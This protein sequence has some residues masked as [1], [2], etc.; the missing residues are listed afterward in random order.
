MLETQEGKGKENM[1]YFE[2]RERLTKKGKPSGY[3]DFTCR[4]DNDIWR[5]GYCRE[6]NCKHKTKVEACDHYRQ[7]QLD[8]ELFLANVTWEN[9]WRECLVDECKNLTNKAA[10]LG[11]GNGNYFDLCPKHMNRETIEQLYP[12]GE[13]REIISS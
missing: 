5:V 1:N 9:T 10:R 4:N 2:A 8:K 3:F 6:M 11:Y 13:E 12:A 7:Y